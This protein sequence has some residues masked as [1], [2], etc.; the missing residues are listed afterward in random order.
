MDFR[1]REYDAFGPWI[2]EINEEHTM[3]PL[4]APYYKQSETPL[5]LFKIPRKI[6]RRSANPS[7]DLYD[8]VIALL[9]A[10]MYIMRR[11]GKRVA[12]QTI[13]YTDIQ[14]VQY[15][16]D[17]LF[18]QI[19]IYTRDSTIDIFYN[20]VSTDIIAKMAVLLSNKLSSAQPRALSISAIPYS[21]ET[22][23][24]LYAAQISK[25]E[26]VNADARL[27]AYQ[28]AVPYN[29]NSLPSKLGRKQLI[30][31]TAFVACDTALVIIKRI[32]DI[33]R[34]KSVDLSCV[35]V[36]LPYQ[37]IKEMRI[38][39]H[40]D[41]KQISLLKIKTANHQF[42]TLFTDKNKQMSEMCDHMVS[43]LSLCKN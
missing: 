43:W 3:P 36:H 14:A 34:T 22:I 30:Q 39:R 15:A 12:E 11:T 26:Q 33:I 37:N 6:E 7:M 35:F 20:A 24:F 38:L 10:K 42:C 25:I 9:D 2:Y 13:A 27:V 1:S 21:L 5:M 28:P 16:N 32:K 31:S 8:Y 17:L 23:E 19:R 41:S 18:A 4:F 29:D 40:R